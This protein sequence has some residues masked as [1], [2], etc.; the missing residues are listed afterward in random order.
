MI[1][2][3][4]RKFNVN[5]ILGQF[6]RDDKGNPVIL[7]DPKGAF[8]D[9]DGN[10]VNQKGYLI[11][12]TTGDVVE[13]EN[14]KKIFDFL[15]LDERGELP[16][17]FNLERFNFNVHDI[18]G[19][20]DRDAE[21]NEIIPSR[22]DADGNLIDRLGRKVNSE[23][24]L[25]DKKGNMVD[26]RGRIK[27]H[28]AIMDKTKGM[29]PMMLNYKGRR[30]DIRE[31]MGDLDKDRNGNIIVRLDKNNNK[32]DRKGCRVNNKGLLVDD[33]GNII[34]KDGKLMFEKFCLSKDNEVPKLFPFLK[35]NID[36]IKGDFELDPVGNPMLHKARGGGMIDNKGQK[37]N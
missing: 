4:K 31:I 36:E 19:Y 35:F 26:K 37:V 15:D 13:K 5:D 7:Q 12:E 9:K 25:V 10:K 33:L 30:Y 34:N 2:A 11:D 14:G 8:I 23:G 24:Y 17:P 27:L 6:D 28:H 29:I 3:E 16:P 18:R 20:F 21:G 22:K 1:D 32:V